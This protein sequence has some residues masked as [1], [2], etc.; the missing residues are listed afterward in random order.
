[1]SKI[2]MREMLEVGAHFGHQTRRWNPKVKKFIFAPRNG[3]HIIDLQKTVLLFEEAY[4]FIVNITSK[5][6]KILFIGTKKQAQDI[7]LKDAIRS[8][9]FFVNNRWLGGMLTNF[10]TIKQSVDRMKK[11]EVMSN[12]GTFKKLPKKEA[13]NLTRN[14]IKL[15]KNL[16]GIKNMNK[17]PKAI[18]VID[19][20]REEIA[21]LEARKLGIKI[22][23]TLDTNCNPDMI[24]YCIPA[25]DDSMRS[26]GLFAGKIADA[27]I[28][29][30]IKYK[31]IMINK[32]AK[33]ESG[34]KKM[35]EK[36]LLKVS[37]K[38][39]GPKVDVV[40]TTIKTDNIVIKDK[41][42]K[43]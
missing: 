43:L 13:V 5:G 6:G 2:K 40:K 39:K 38:R 15:E 41:N 11:L 35:S 21:V 37:L 42:K 29:G 19:P 8:K 9:Q 12:D 30:E 33:F 10:K 4:N 18:F 23:A 32:K 31:E 20:K 7:I 27:C 26:I 14:L 36:D 34:L 22:I 28:D 17:L 24:D 3:I 25:N 16:S 1:M